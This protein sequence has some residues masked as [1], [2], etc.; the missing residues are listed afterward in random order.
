MNEERKT[1]TVY[2]D[3]E[4]MLALWQY[5]ASKTIQR[6]PAA[7]NIIREGLMQRGFLQEKKNEVGTI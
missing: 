2:L 5:A 1:I 6:S 7:A 3:R 4:T